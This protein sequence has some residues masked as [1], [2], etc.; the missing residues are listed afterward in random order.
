MTGGFKIAGLAILALMA[1]LVLRDSLVRSNLESRPGWAAQVWPEHPETAIAEGMILIGKAAAAHRAVNASLTQPVIEA[2]RGSPLSVAPFLVEGVKRQEA[3][4]EVSAGKLFLAAEQRNPREVAPHYFLAAHY[5]KSGQAGLGLTELGKIIRLV[6]GSAAQL[7]PRIAAG[8]RQAGG[9]AMIRSLVAES[10]E[11][12]DDLMRAM[13][14]D[15]NNL[16]FL[17]SLRTASSA[18]DWQPIMVQSLINAG[19]YDKA[20]ELWGK[21]NG[22]PLSATNRP[23]IMDPSFRLSAPPPF[24]WTLASGSSG[25]AEGSEGGLHVVS[26]ERDPFVVATQTLLLP[27]GSYLL[28]QKIITASSSAAVLNWQISCL[29]P[30]RKIAAFAP[31]P[32]KSDILGKFTVPAGCAAQRIDLIS[33]A[34]DDPQTADFMLGP[35][36]L[37]QAA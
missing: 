31:S 22:M 13:A 23:L 30:D 3:G 6:P 16:D 32:A 33:N 9:A 34:V 8:A 4:D 36:A 15:G 28:A 19:K 18:A 17:L 5:A 1:M 29:G 7:A 21:A 14:T 10:P 37:G 11:L 27:P 12:R 24:G 35:L 25:V 20:L 2:V 26:Y